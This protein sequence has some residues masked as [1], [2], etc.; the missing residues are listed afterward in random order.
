MYEV[1]LHKG[2]PEK[3]MGKKI[4]GKILQKTTKDEN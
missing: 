4:F 2:V 3:K 1:I